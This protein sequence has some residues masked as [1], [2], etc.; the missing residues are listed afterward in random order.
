[1]EAVIE[2]YAK[3]GNPAHQ[4]IH[5]LVSANKYKLLMSLDIYKRMIPRLL[6]NSATY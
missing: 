6:L 1:M 4:D 5:I 2:I 3:T